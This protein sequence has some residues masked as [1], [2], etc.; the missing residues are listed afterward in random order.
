MSRHRK[1]AFCLL[2]LLSERSPIGVGS[3]SLEKKREALLSVFYCIGRAKHTQT[4]TN[5]ARNFRG[6][7]NGELEEEEEEGTRKLG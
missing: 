5:E 2:P 7:Q 1:I 6:R 4:I 3:M